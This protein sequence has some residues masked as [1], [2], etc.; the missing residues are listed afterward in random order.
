MQD[1]MHITSLCEILLEIERHCGESRIPVFYGQVKTKAK[2]TVVWESVD[3]ANNWKTYLATLAL[4]PSKLLHIHVVSSEGLKT[5][6]AQTL[7]P[8]E[9]DLV[10]ATRDDFADTGETHKPVT[11]I[12]EIVLTFFHQRRAYQWTAGKVRE[13]P[14]I[15]Q[16]I[17]E[18]ELRQAAEEERE[19]Q[20]YFESI[21]ESEVDRIVLDPIYHSA[22]TPEQRRRTVVLLLEQTPFNGKEQTRIAIRCEERFQAE[23]EQASEHWK[24]SMN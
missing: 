10:T 3:P 20:A 1:R 18:D 9:Y 23:A 4:L 8:H 6:E 7:P 12:R 19:T 2:R 15:D 24:K 5:D 17:T 13:S 11:D 14:P 22:P 21:L 16:G